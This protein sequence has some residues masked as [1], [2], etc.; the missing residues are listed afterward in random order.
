MKI[1]N[2]VSDPIYYPCVAIYKG[3]RGTS[4]IILLLAHGYWVVEHL[5]KRLNVTNL[6]VF[7]GRQ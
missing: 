3:K 1:K 7:V 4:P 2:I 6:D 5:T